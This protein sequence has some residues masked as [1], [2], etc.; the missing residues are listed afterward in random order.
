MS[1]TRLACKF[2]FLLCVSAGCLK[3][4]AAQEPQLFVSPEINFTTRTIKSATV[5]NWL[6]TKRFRTKMAI[7]EQLFG[8]KQLVLRVTDAGTGKL[9]PEYTVQAI[10]V[11]LD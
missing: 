6:S 7:Q 11:W 8:R 10:I 3:R 2:I 4:C 9:V 5:E 1:M